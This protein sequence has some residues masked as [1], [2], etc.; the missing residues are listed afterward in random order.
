VGQ[1]ARQET[2]TQGSYPSE[3]GKTQKAE[4]GKD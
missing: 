1:V 4:K 2:E 3:E